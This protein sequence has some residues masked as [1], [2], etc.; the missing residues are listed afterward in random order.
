M[1]TPTLPISPRPTRVRWRKLDNNTSYRSPFTGASETQE[2][3]GSRWAATLEFKDWRRD[4]LADLEAFLWSLRGSA[5]RFWLW[6]HAREEIRGSGAGSPIVV[7]DENLLFHSES[8]GLSP[9]SAATVTVQPDVIVGP[10]G[11]LTADRVVPDTG[12]NAHALPQSGVDY[13]EG[14][15]YTLSIYGKADQY[16]GLVLGTNNAI[17]PSGYR[18]VVAD[19]TAGE[20]VNVVGSPPGYGIKD[21]GD[22]W[23][24]VWVTFVA[25]ATVNTA[26]KLQVRNAVNG[27]SVPDTS[28]IGDGTSGLY[29][30]GAQLR[31]SAMPGRYVAS[32][33]STVAS[34][35]PLGGT[36]YT[37]GWTPNAAGVLLPGDLIGVG[38]ELKA[39]V[40][41]VDADAAGIAAV[42]IE[43]PLRA[44]PANGSALVLS[45]PTVLMKLVNDVSE[46]DFARTLG[47]LTLECEEAF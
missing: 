27:A 43:P 25:E 37:G 29:L 13:E 6:H 18:A 14:V 47:S 40:G 36:L 19:F 3:P 32:G 20:L 15:V 22:G 16:S 11:E 42:P 12:N 30:T 44:E 35:H 34:S 23:F 26:F 31:R 5:G 8:L 28:W 7:H 38:G 46:I 9:W 4:E 1:T 2:R 41:T 45:R 21:E 24:R 39:V 33:A 10:D 17:T